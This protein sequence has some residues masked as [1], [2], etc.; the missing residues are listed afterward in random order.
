MKTD[1]MTHLKV[2]LIDLLYLELKFKMFGNILVKYERPIE[3]LTST[4]SLSIFVHNCLEN[5]LVEYTD[6]FLNNFNKD[7]EDSGDVSLTNI[8][9]FL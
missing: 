4:Q 2:I 9:L 5:K 8:L 6:S 3:P 7:V 1:K